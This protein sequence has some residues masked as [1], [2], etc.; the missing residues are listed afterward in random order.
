[1]ADWQKDMTTPADRAEKSA[2]KQIERLD[3][4]ESEL[5][6]YRSDAQRDARQAKRREIVMLFFTAATVIISLVA[7][8]K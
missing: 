4:L 2:E 1:M 3:R 5:K 7:L 6:R 8:I